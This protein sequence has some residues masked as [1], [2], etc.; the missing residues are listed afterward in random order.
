M[1][2]S[3][4]EADKT[5]LAKGY[6]GQMQW[7]SAHGDKRFRPEALGPHAIISARMD[8]LPRYATGENA[9]RKRQGLRLHALGRD[10]HNRSANGLPHWRESGRKW[11]T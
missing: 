3:A 6:Q 2:L 8:Y 5:W 10:Y 4:A 7:M 11:A 1:D 9:G